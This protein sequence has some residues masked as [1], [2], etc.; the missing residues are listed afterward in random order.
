MF[1]QLFQ[2]D[3]QDTSFL[4]VLSCTVVYCCVVYCTVGA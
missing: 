3:R 1:F 2:T 4:S